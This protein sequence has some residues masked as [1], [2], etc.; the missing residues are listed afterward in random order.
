MRTG[1][2]YIAFLLIMGI[3]AIGTTCCTPKVE[4]Q[5]QVDAD[6][7]V[8]ID[9]AAVE[10]IRKD[11]TEF[12]KGIIMERL[13]KVDSL[14]VDTLDQNVDDTLQVDTSEWVQ[15]DILHLSGGG[16]TICY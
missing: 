8:N 3:L 6:I 11:G 16:L 2:H 7:E 1:A 13:N 4:V 5:P 14:A 15:P 10:E 9:S 12:V